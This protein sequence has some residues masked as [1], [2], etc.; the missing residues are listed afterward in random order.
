GPA[1]KK[2]LSELGLDLVLMAFTGGSNAD[3]HL[4]SLEE[5]VEWQRQLAPLFINAHSGSDR[6]NQDQ[7]KRFYE[8]AL[9]I[10]SRAGVP[11]AHETHRGRVFFNPWVTRDIIQEFPE[12]KLTCD[13]SHWV[14]VAERLLDDEKEILELCA[15]HAMHIHGRVGYEEGPQVPDPR[16][17]EYRGYL[18]AHERWWDMIWNSQQARGVA[19][20]T[21]TPEFGPPSYM[22]TLPYTNVPV[23]DLWDICNWMAKREAERFRARPGPKE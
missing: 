5:Q 4:R 18:E 3:E 8:G 13:Y 15:R 22:H 16:A 23:A 10:E 9:K 6:W 20:S 21:L 12:L 19:V 17:P 14:C 2:Q 1:L 11:I 7:A